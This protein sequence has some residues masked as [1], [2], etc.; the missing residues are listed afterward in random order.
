MRFF[1]WILKL[2]GGG[3]E[4]QNLLPSPAE[5]AQ[6]L[7][8]VQEKKDRT[9]EII[10]DSQDKIKKIHE[11]T[12]LAEGTIYADKF[13]LVLEWT[14]KIHDGIIEEE[15]VS[16]NRLEQFHLYYTDEFLNTFE[17]A[18]NDLKPKQEIDIKLKSSYKLQQELEAERLK[19]EQQDIINNIYSLGT[20]ER[21]ELLLKY[22][23]DS[24]KLIQEKEY[25]DVIE[26]DKSKGVT[27][28]Y[29]DKYSAYLINNWNL[30]KS[31]KFIG[32]LNDKQETPIVYD[33]NTLDVYKIL[34]DSANPEKLGNIKDETIKDIVERGHKK[35]APISKAQQG[36]YHNY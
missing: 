10:S 29:A 24:W 31:I 13:K 27:V 34:Y 3:R 16:N 1:D 28:T 11:L 2:F 12:K 9:M 19:K 21:I 17:E 36:A 22:V 7:V 6:E 26:K 32:E 23:N 8:K 15:K 33:I 30:P 5:E 4:E 14:R 35:K 18:L 25:H 20:K